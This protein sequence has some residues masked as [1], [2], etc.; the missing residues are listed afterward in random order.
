MKKLILAAALSCVFSGVALAQQSGSL[1]SPSRGATYFNRPGA[2]LEGHRADL[3]ACRA[4][5]APLIQP[6]PNSSGAAVAAGSYGLAGAL[7][8]TAMDAQA[9]LVATLK[10]MHANY[11]N[12][13]VVRGWRVVQLD[14]SVG[15]E[16]DDLDAEA[17]AARLAPMVGAETPEGRVVRGF[18]NEIAERGTTLYMFPREP[19]MTS[20][21]LQLLPES[22][23]EQPRR[24]M[25]RSISSM[26]TAEIRAQAE[27]RR[28]T[29]EVARV[30]SDALIGRSRRFL[31]PTAAD[32][33]ASLPSDA[34]LI[35]VRAY[36]AGGAGLVLVRSDAAEGEDENDS[37]F[38]QAPVPRRR[39]PAEERTYVFAVPP[40]NWRL[41]ALSP[42]PVLTSL[43][44]GAP[45]F[46]VAAGEVVFAGSFGFGQSGP[47]M[48]LA[49]DPARVALAPAPALA[50]RVQAA[51]YTNGDTFQCG[52]PASYIY[53]YEIDGAPFREGYG[54][55][56][57]AQ[58]A[59]EE[60]STPATAV[61]EDPV[62]AEQES[63][64]Q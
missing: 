49:L 6:F 53:A 56:S 39:D 11:E 46:N 22:Y 7:V 51:S 26:T 37:L 55:G 42:G 14:A 19:D 5:V 31:E 48:D 35:V 27:E 16:L 44:L 28:R 13:M 23:L 25:N 17:L 58:A 62:T 8:G 21:S 52:A 50:E 64:P 20:L 36:G 9:Q 63:T 40:G 33:I 60:M 30:Q 2:T 3:D 29:L 34:T 18:N 1:V 45:S 15:E 24:R 61:A 59:P 12:C 4:D 57:R 47:R 10:A 54:F 43:C 41:T 32:E 38:A